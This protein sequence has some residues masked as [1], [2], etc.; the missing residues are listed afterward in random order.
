[1]LIENKGTV[2]NGSLVIALYD[3]SILY[4]ILARNDSPR[5]YTHN[6][7]KKYEKLLTRLPG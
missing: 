6:Y 1:M 5:H 4:I 2:Q 7:T 3:M